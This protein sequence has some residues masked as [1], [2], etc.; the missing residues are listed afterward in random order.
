MC[1]EE[2]VHINFDE[3]NFSTSGQDINNVKIG[4]AN[5]EDDEEEMKQQ[6]QGTAGDQPIQEDA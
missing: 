3:T 1:V 6:D 5:L 4:L 2:S